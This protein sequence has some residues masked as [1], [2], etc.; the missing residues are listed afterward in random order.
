MTE[1]QAQTWDDDG[2]RVPSE[3]AELDLSELQDDGDVLKLDDG[4]VLRLRFEGDSDASINDY[5][6][7]GKVEW[8][9]RRDVRGYGYVHSVRPDGFTGAARIIDRDDHYDLWW[10]PYEELTTEQIR[11]EEPRIRDLVRYGFKG[12]IL[13]LCNGTDAYGRP[14]VENVASL[15]AVEW[16]ADAA[17]IAEIVSDLASELV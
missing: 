2:G 15:W 4:R 17:Y 13:E 12:V 5:E 8:M 6:S 9:R 3:Q 11:A 7:D 14:I 10:Q 16:D 1:L